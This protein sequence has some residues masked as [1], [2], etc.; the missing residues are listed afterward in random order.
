MWEKE[1]GREITGDEFVRRYSVI[2][3]ISEEKARTRY[4]ES[5]KIKIIRN[6]IVIND[7][8]LNIHDTVESHYSNPQDEAAADGTEEIIRNELETLLNTYKDEDK[9]FYRALLTARIITNNND[10]KNYKE[11]LPFL[12]EEIIKDYEKNGK[13]PPK[14]EIY[15]RCYPNAKKESAQSAA[16]PKAQEF[17]KAFEKAEEAIYKK[18]GLLY[19]KQ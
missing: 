8:E 4:L 1:I 9:P 7:E 18:L 3:Q 2:K 13:I 6:T 14:Y 10:K 11:I 12:D 16:S 17:D 15:M 5:M 19:K